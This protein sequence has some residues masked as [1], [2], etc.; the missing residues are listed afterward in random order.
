MSSR[1]CAR[2]RSDSNTPS[3]QRSGCESSGDDSQAAAWATVSWIAGRAAT[4]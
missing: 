2:E 4:R 1:A 3:A